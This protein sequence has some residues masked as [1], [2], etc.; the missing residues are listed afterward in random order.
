MGNPKRV[1]TAEDEQAIRDA[2]QAAQSADAAV[3]EAVLSAHSHGASI[4]VLSEFTG[5][6]TNTI[7][8]WKKDAE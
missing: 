7:M 8:R 4:R 6:S 1:L 5:M 2:M 3:R